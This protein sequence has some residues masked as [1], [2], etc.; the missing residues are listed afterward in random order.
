MQKYSHKGGGGGYLKDQLRPAKQASD[1]FTFLPGVDLFR[2]LYCKLFLS[3]QHPMLAFCFP[4]RGEGR[5]RH[6]SCHTVVLHFFLTILFRRWCVI[7]F[8]CLLVLF[9]VFAEFT[10]SS[11]VPVW[12]GKGHVACI[13]KVWAMCLFSDHLCVRRRD[14]GSRQGGTVRLASFDTV[15]PKIR[16]SLF[17]LVSCY[18]ISHNLHDTFETTA[19]FQPCPQ[20]CSNGE[21]GA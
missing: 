12:P 4:K 6:C 2:N 3:C 18:S 16:P 10:Q 14:T 1:I 9:F 20:H 17:S 7:I 8:W 5:E 15:P 11:P 19:A 13:F 21:L